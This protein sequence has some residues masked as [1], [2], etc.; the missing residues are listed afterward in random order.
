M[1]PGAHIRV[2]WAKNIQAPEK[3]HVVRF[4]KIVMALMALLQKFCLKSHE[5]L[6]LLDD[7]NLL[8]QKHLRI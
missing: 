1:Y 8:T 2:K 7:Y 6:F 3:I 5:P 4:P